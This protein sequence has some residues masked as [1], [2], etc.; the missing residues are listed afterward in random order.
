MLMRQ[1]HIQT[2]KKTMKC[3]EVPDLLCIAEG[4]P[5]VELVRLLKSNFCR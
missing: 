3:R 5:S 4:A 1:T 2:E